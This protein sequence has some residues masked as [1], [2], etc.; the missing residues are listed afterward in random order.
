MVYVIHAIVSLNA[1]KTEILL[2]DQNQ[3][4]FVKDFGSDL[5]EIVNSEGETKDFKYK[6]FYNQESKFAFYE[7]F[8]EKKI[9]DELWYLINVDVW[10]GIFFISIIMF[11]LI[12]FTIMFFTKKE[13]V[14]HDKK[15]E[16]FFHF[17]YTTFIVF[18]FGYQL[19]ITFLTITQLFNCLTNDCYTNYDRYSEKKIL[20]DSFNIK[21]V[22]LYNNLK[23]QEGATFIGY[24]GVC[25]SSKLNNYKT[26]I[27]VSG[28]KDIKTKEFSS[29]LIKT[30]YR[31]WYRKDIN[32]AYLPENSDELTSWYLRFL[33]IIN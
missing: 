16:S 31:I 19:W 8:I 24:D 3:E 27:L 7:P 14:I 1:G 10:V 29:E 17:L 23:Y 26:K 11:F 6:I 18:S 33:N 25:F 13:K 32:I 15:Q 20:I 5:F 21:E 22:F 9:L 28:N 12:S 2:I 30:D 4:Y